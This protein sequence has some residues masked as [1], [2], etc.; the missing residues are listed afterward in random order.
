M[1]LPHDA[2]R[3]AW[4]YLSGVAEPPT[5]FDDRENKSGEQS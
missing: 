1:P 5:P 4:A 2:V 3:T